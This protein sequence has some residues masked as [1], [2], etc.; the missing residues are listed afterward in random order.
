MPREATRR[1]FAHRLNPQVTGA[2]TRYGVITT[3]D[4][5]PKKKAV[6]HS[7]YPSLA[8][9]ILDEVIHKLIHKTCESIVDSRR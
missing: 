9:S 1:V 7:S 8:P 6:W 4:T 2:D 5:M 3:E